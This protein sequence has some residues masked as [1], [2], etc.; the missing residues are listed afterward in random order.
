MEAGQSGTYLRLTRASSICLSDAHPRAGRRSR[1]SQVSAVLSSFHIYLFKINNKSINIQI[2]FDICVDCNVRRILLAQLMVLTRTNS[3]TEV[4][5]VPLPKTNICNS[6]D[7]S[8]IALAVINEICLQ[9]L[10]FASAPTGRSLRRM[11]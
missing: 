3:S 7:C 10:P 11:E 2:E 6:T 9:F 4:Q 1:Q 8:A 5:L